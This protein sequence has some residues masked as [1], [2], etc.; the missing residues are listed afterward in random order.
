M[1]WS[2]Y[3]CIIVAMDP[4]GNLLHSATGCCWCSCVTRC[5]IIKLLIVS[6]EML[7]WDQNNPFSWKWFDGE[8]RI[9]DSRWEL[10]P[11]ST[12]WFLSQSSEVWKTLLRNP[13]PRCEVRAQNCVAQKC[14]ASVSSLQRILD[15]V[16]SCES[17]LRR[18]R[19]LRLSAWCGRFGGERPWKIYTIVR[20]FKASDRLNSRAILWRECERVGGAWMRT[21]IRG[22]QG[23][24]MCARACVCVL[25]CSWTQRKHGQHVSYMPPVICI[26]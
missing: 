11:N 8:Q 17:L 21:R 19:A 7:P 25:A 1:C 26:D 18:S 14:P 24:L 6:G 3:V 22:E 9:S 20:Y 10:K 12:E 2:S 13:A 16:A 4:G 15:L 5:I 23:E